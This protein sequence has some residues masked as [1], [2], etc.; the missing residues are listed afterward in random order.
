MR[1]RVFFLFILLISTIAGSSQSARQN[2]FEFIKL[3]PT[4]DSVKIQKRLSLLK[5]EIKSEEDKVYYKLCEADRFNYSNNTSAAINA[6]FDALSLAKS[7]G[8][9]ELESRVY[10]HLGNFYEQKNNL[11]KALT[12]Y[13]QGLSA[14]TENF[15]DS[16]Y[17][18]LLYRKALIYKYLDDDQNEKK[19]LDL[20]LKNASRQPSRIM[21]SDIYNLLGLYYN[22]DNIPDSAKFYFD[23]SLELRVRH[24]ILRAIGQSYNNLGALYFSTGDYRT[25]LSFFQKSLYMRKQ[26]NK[27]ITGILESE[28]NIG[29]AYYKL[30]DLKNASFYLENAARRSDSIG[31]IELKRRILEIYIEMAEKNG[32]FKKAL[33]FQ[34]DYYK[35]V[36][37][38]YSSKKKEDILALTADFETD[39]RMKQDSMRRVQAEE[40]T[41]LEIEKK[42]AIQKQTIYIITLLILLLG[43]LAFFARYLYRENKIKQEKND[44]ITKQHDLLRVKQHE[45]NDSIN[46]AGNIQQA[47]LPSED[48]FKNNCDDFFVL[49]YPKDIVSGDFFWATNKQTSEGDFFI[50]VTADC[51]GHGVPGAFMSLI[52]ISFLNEIIN[53]EG[54]I[55]P[56]QILNKLR[57]KL[58]SAINKEGKVEK[59]DGLDGLV[60]VIDKRNNHLKYAGANEI[61]FVAH[62][63]E[64]TYLIQDY[65]ADKMPVGKG[66]KDKV[67]FT[68]YE[69]QLQKGDIIYTCTDG[70]ADQFGGPGNKKLKAKHVKIKLNEICHLPLVHQKDELR[71]F[72]FN[73][74]GNFEQIDD[75]TFI[76]VKL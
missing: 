70:F 34:R 24:K 20:L 41:M 35:I 18:E 27:R 56:D 58:I 12:N 76:G 60:C 1:S 28:I 5:S 23:K 49:F 71:N 40:K 25:A 68:C 59:Q 15:S 14:I 61:F 13:N 54:I 42:K 63:K 39:R 52:S 55:T 21:E 38:L 2:Y 29:K 32:D 75:V 31:H 16:N 57:S 46:Y 17:V 8:K 66:P 69:L 37:S 22:E 62:K 6:F 30:N 33:A 10:A 50:Y 44:L 45:I 72:F 67:P 4:G 26:Y 73:W 19:I 43:G 51:T 7:S 36:D 64:N 11:P 47:L 53:E 65:K 48:I 9:K 3:L 74:K